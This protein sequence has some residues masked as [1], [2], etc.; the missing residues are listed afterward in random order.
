MIRFGSVLNR[1]K[2][3]PFDRFFRE[4]LVVCKVFRDG[5]PPSKACVF[6]KL[7]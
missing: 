3:F 4:R 6:R 7:S 1:G 2:S 5:A